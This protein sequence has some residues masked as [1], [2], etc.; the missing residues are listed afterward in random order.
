MT[1][2][3]RYTGPELSALLR[4]VRAELG[5][6]AT[7]HEANR[8]RTGGIGGFF[9]KE[10]FEV[11]AS[12]PA[13]GRRSES[14]SAGFVGRPRT[15]GEGAIAMGAGTGHLAVS[16]SL[17]ADEELIAKLTAAMASEQA[18]IDAIGASATLPPR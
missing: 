8:I 1:T 9:R 18:W 3:Q 17:E 4:E 2:Q 7:I 14:S 6:Q 5:D 13:S 10:G 16:E 12:P 11:L 15:S